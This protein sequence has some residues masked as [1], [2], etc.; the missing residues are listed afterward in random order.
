MSVLACPQCG[1]RDAV[2]KRVIVNSR[3]RRRWWIFGPIIAAPEVVG[4]V[5]LCA[6]CAT[7]F[8]VSPSGVFVPRLGEQSFRGASADSKTAPHHPLNDEPRSL[9]DS[10]QPWESAQKR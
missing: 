8:C 5:H 6:R 10:D 9:R 7:E 2:P 3:L 4:N 1:S